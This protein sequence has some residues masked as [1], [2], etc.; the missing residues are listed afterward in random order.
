M[1][2]LLVT[3]V[4]DGQVIV[5]QTHRDSCCLRFKFLSV[6]HPPHGHPSLTITVSLE[7][8]VYILT[9]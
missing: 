2:S 8:D 7:L 1:K 9:I 3:E 4:A 6:T 5:S